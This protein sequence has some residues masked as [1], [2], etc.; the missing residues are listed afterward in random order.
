MFKSEVFIPDHTK[1]SPDHVQYKKHQNAMRLGVEIE[2]RFG[3][4]KTR[5]EEV[6]GDVY[7][8]EIAAFPRE[9]WYKFRRDL[10]ALVQGT[11]LYESVAVLMKTL[12]SAGHQSIK[13]EP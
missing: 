11:P 10:G 3:S 8:L 2:N 4:E 12:E 6:L 1:L 9:A 13:V 5:D 7:K